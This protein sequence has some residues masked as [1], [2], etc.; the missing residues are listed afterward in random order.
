MRNEEWKTRKPP[1]RYV[2]FLRARMGIEG[3]WSQ[4]Q[5]HSQDTKSVSFP[6]WERDAFSLFTLH[7][8]LFTF[9]RAK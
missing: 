6:N 5:D 3:V 9:R 7:S 2:V 8:S 4:E 1:P